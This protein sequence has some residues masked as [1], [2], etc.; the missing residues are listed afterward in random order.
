M[1]IFISDNC[2]KEVKKKIISKNAYY[3]SLSNSSHYYCFYLGQWTANQDLTGLWSIS[4]L[5][6]DPRAFWV[7]LPTLSPGAL[8][9]NSYGPTTGSWFTTCYSQTSGPSCSPQELI[10]SSWTMN[11]N[12]HEKIN[13][14]PS[15]YSMRSH[16]VRWMLDSQQLLGDGCHFLPWCNCW[17]VLPAPVKSL[18]LLLWQEVVLSP[19][20]SAGNQDMPIEGGV[21][22]KCANGRGGPEEGMG[23]RTTKFIIWMHDTV[24]Q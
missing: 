6:L 2:F 4:F 11:P 23:L 13:L 9:R 10:F 19:S 17:W 1:I 8:L 24:K 7:V 3:K 18:Q 21:V 5:I 20:D 16:L 15:F 12:R 14:V 22:E